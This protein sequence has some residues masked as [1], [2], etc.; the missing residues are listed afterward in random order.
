MPG[1]EDNLKIRFCAGLT[2]LVGGLFSSL[3]GPAAGAQ[4]ASPATVIRVVD[5]ETLEAQLDDGRQVPVRLIGI[6]TPEVSPAECGAGGATESLRELVEGRPVSLVSDPTQDSVDRFGRMLAYVDRDDGLDVGEAQLRRGWGEVL[7]YERRFQ[8]QGL[9]E[10]AESEGMVFSR[11]VWRLCDG[12]FHRSPAEQRAA[13]LRARRS[14]AVAFMRRYF[15]RVSNRQFVTVWR[16]L[17]PRVRRSFGGFVRWRLGYRRSLRT[18]VVRAR[19]RL[20][21]GRAVVTITIRSLDRD[22]CGGRIVRQRFSGR[23]ILAPRSDSWIVVR[24]RMRKTAG[25]RVRLSKSE[26]PPPPSRPQ[27]PARPRPRNCQGYSPCLPPGP[28]VDCAGGSGN[29]P[30]YVEGPVR[31][32][33]DDPY[34]LDSDGN[35]VGCE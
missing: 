21:L 28:D 26:C 9:Y 35:G 29:G 12:D 13:E 3:V 19:A 31:V 5:G 20:S 32:R 33:G 8:R 2:L 4:V 27:P 25:G 6:D 18:S 23:W 34:G 30:R 1:E 15:R 14:S 10:D 11:G 17:A 24:A 16:T 7:V 22:A